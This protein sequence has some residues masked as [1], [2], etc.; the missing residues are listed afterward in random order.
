MYIS[1]NWL[2][3]AKKSISKKW[4]R[5]SL[6]NNDVDWKGSIGKKEELYCLLRIEKA[7]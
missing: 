3:E 6:L 7:Q 5:S 1:V 2:S 4:A